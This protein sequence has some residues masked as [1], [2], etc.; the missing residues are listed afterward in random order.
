MIL[1]DRNFESDIIIN[2][3]KLDDE[4]QKHPGIYYYYSEE[5]AKLKSRL[6]HE[7][8]KLSFMESELEL[9]IR[10]DPPNSIKVTEQTIKAYINSDTN[11]KKQRE[12]VN[13][14]KKQIYHYETAVKVLEHKKIMIKNLV[15]LFISRYYSEPKEDNESN[16]INNQIRKNLRR[17]NV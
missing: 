10:K 6:D 3:Y 9:S 4:C 2:K 11:L 14:I 13:N 5:L 8:E 7:K 16:N 15:E 17:N 12:E 1:T